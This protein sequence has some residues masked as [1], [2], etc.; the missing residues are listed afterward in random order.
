M[1]EFVFTLEP[2]NGFTES[3]ILDILKQG[4]ATVGS[5]GGNVYDKDGVL[6]AQVAGV[7][8]DETKERLL[9]LRDDLRWRLD[10]CWCDDGRG[11]PECKDCCKWREEWNYLNKLIVSVV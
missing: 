2:H 6:V 11:L 4:Q 9:R 7:S 5:L 10:D 3:Q 1:F 8:K